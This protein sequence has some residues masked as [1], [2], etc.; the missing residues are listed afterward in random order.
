MGRLINPG[1]GEL[2][3][4]LTILQRKIAEATRGGR[5]FG[6]FRDEK[7]VI[8]TQL[9]AAGVGDRCIEEILELATI[10]NMLW[11]AED[12]LRAFRDAPDRLRDEDALNVAVCVALKIQELND[13]RN[14]C[15]A[16]INSK[17]GNAGL[18]PEKG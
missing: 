10:N 6:H 2:A 3:D 14:E 17:T 8:V 13:T 15:I 18:G 4:R 12:Q 5:P 16:K 9:T 7:N 11:Q 1:P